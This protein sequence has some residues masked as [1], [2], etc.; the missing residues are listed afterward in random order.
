MG[1]VERSKSDLDRFTGDLNGFG[2]EFTII[3]PSGDEEAVV[4]GY[5]TKHH[6]QFT[7]DGS[8]ISSKIASIAVTES[9]FDALGFVIRNED[10]EVDIKSYRVK[11]ADSTGGIKEYVVRESYPD[12][13]LGLIVLIL[14]DYELED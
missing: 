10:G 1:L 9:K 4:I 11:A 8:T 5:H 6:R 3:R 2:E 13:Q 7:E 14:A 12:E